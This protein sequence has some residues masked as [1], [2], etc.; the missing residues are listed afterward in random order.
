[1]EA[2]N[3]VD[4]PLYLNWAIICPKNETA[5][6]DNNNFF[7]SNGTTRG[8]N[9]NHGTNTALFMHC[10]SINTDK[11]RIIAHMRHVL[12]G[13]SDSSPGSADPRY[14]GSKASYI[15]RERYIKLAR[16]LQF[17]N[18]ADTQPRSGNVYL[19]YWINKM[20][21]GP[22]LTVQTDLG[23]LSLEIVAYFRD[24]RP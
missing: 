18:A 11:Y 1:M 4:T 24:P 20:G 10:K 2:R 23:A 9:F 6:P 13:K 12:G 5:I 22:N 14:S 17:E 3:D 7:R 21:D 19:V 8:E 16:Q 15:F